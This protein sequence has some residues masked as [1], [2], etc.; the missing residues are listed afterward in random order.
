MFDTLATTTLTTA[1]ETFTSKATELAT[2]TTTQN[3][4]VYTDVPCGKQPYGAVWSSPRR[5]DYQLYC[6]GYSIGGTNVVQIS[7]I[8]TSDLSLCLLFCDTIFQPD[9]Q[10][11]V[12]AGIDLCY[13]LKDVS[14]VVS[15]GANS[16]A[17]VRRVL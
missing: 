1:I 9:C 17:A 14:M 16:H 10:A 2:A 7:G 8:A 6:N 4:A 3:L 13:L 15:A 11:V 5:T 12:R